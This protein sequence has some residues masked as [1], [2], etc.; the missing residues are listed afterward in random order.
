MRISMRWLSDYVSL[1]AGVGPADV[2]R[3]LT[4]RTVEVEKVTPTLDGD[5]VLEVDNK[6]LTNRPDLWG[7]YGMARELSAIYRVPLHD[8]PQGVRPPSTTGLVGDLDP[9]VCSRFSAVAYAI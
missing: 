7:H 5:T 3:E 1:P 8:L 6:S 2:A 9:A 4:L